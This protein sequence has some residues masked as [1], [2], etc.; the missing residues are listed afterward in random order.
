[1]SSGFRCS[2]CN[3]IHPPAPHSY[4]I[5]APEIYISLN[6]EE[7]ETRTQISADQ[8]IVDGSQFFLRGRIIV[9]I[10]SQ[11]FRPA[12]ELLNFRATSTPQLRIDAPYFVYGCWVE[13]SPS[14]FSRTHELWTTQGRE[15]E[16]P[17]EAYFATD[18]YH[19]PKT[20]N[21]RVSVST[22]PVGRRPNFRIL[23]ETHPLAAEQKMGIDAERI[24][25]IAE[26]ILHLK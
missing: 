19:Y 13:V 11:H 22:Q 24:Q 9:P 15:N 25:K 16:P 5:K 6:E 12:P 26:Q 21:L 3:L 7:R 10:L 17:F 2:I 23:D 8:C 20:M 18:L 1:M 4:S 14:D